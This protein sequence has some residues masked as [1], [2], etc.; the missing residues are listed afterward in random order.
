MTSP[1]RRIAVALS[2]GVDSA[3]TLAL[4][5]RYKRKFD[6]TAV[7]MSNWDPLDDDMVSPCRQSGASDLE[8]CHRVCSA[9]D[10]PLR[11][12]S[13]VKEYWTDVFSPMIVDYEAGLTP[14]PDVLCNRFVKF[15]RLFEWVERE[16]GAEGV[17]TGHYA[18]TSFGSY[19]ELWE[20]KKA[21]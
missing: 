2:G 9:L 21:G 16:L 17:A 13:F 5:K 6:L 4:L 7:Y 20:V 1:F 14:N 19:G 11:V 8:F 12:V 18:R 15:G 3:V 10:V